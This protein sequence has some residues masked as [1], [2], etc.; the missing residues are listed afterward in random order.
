MA[1][2]A[3]ELE[4][5]DQEVEILSRGLLEWG[6]PAQPTEE[7]AVALGFADVPNL[8]DR[9]SWLR[10]RLAA[11]DGLEPVDWARVLTSVEIVF[12]SDVFGSGYEWS[13]TTGWHD[14]ETIQALRR[15]QRKL[16]GTVAPVIGNGFGTRPP[17]TSAW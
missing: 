1:K 15:I 11:G 4:L 12:V 9:C 8:M 2:T 6:G 14:E 13:T 10:A 3:Q 7:M 5:T 17:P 16:V